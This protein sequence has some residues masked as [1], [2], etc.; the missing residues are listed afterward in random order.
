MPVIEIMG[1]SGLNDITLSHA[2]YVDTS[3]YNAETGDL[4]LEYLSGNI[5]NETLLEQGFG[6]YVNKDNVQEL[7]TVLE[8]QIDSSTP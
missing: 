5:P 3:H 2:N 6:V 1:F 7:I 4:M 8:C